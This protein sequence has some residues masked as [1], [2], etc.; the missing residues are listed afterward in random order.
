MVWFERPPSKRRDDKILQHTPTTPRCGRVLPQRFGTPLRGT[1]KRLFNASAWSMTDGEMYQALHRRSLR[2]CTCLSRR[3]GNCPKRTCFLGCRVRVLQLTTYPPRPSPSA[4]TSSATARTRTPSSA[5]FS[6]S[7][8]S[9]VLPAITRRSASSPPPGSTSRRPPARSLP[10]R[11]SGA[12]ARR[13][14]SW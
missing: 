7:R 5:S 2:T 3:Y 12:P 13:V 8:V 4:S 10:K 6:S 1:R 9:T 14:V 11:R